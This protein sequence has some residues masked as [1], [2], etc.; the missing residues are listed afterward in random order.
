MLVVQELKSKTRHF[1]SHLDCQKTVSPNI[2]AGR[3]NESVTGSP[4]LPVAN[5]VRQGAA[6]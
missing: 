2:C 1:L 6:A 5:A 4:G 3:A